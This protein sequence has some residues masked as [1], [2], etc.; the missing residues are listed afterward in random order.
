MKNGAAEHVAIRAFLRVRRRGG[1]EA[2]DDDPGK[3][4]NVK[5]LKYPRHKER[6]PISF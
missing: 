3:A 5:P 6:I 1:Q 4:S 2:E